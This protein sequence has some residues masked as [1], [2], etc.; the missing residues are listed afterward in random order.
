[1]R[2]EEGRGFNTVFPYF[3][4]P[5]LIGEFKNKWRSAAMHFLSSLLQIK[6]EDKKEI[7]SDGIEGEAEMAKK[8]KIDR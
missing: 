7:G 1:M 4:E 5:K 8:M 3:N 6:M 2:K